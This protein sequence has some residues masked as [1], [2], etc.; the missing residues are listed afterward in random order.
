[1]K[2]Y[3]CP[4]CNQMHTELP[5]LIKPYRQYEQSVIDAV[6]H[7]HIDTFAGDDSTIRYWKGKK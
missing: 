2:R 1:M 6:Q 7:G 4:N 5:D 3:Y